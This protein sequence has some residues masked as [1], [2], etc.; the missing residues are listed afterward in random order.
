MVCS[1]HRILEVLAVL[2]CCPSHR[3]RHRCRRRRRH[4][5]SGGYVIG[6]VQVGVAEYDQE[7]IAPDSYHCF[8]RANVAHEEPGHLH[9]HAVALGVT[10]P[11]VVLL[12]VIDVEIDAAPLSLWLCFALPR[13]C[14]QITTVVATSQRIADAQLEELGL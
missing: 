4:A 7:L 1:N 10:I 11:V 8:L 12:E 3:E 6:L 13:H 2:A 9:Q 5:Q 14:I